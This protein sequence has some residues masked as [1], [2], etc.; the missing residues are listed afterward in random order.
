ML[1]PTDYDISPYGSQRSLRLRTVPAEDTSAVHFDWGS[2]P[3][4]AEEPDEPRNL[5]ELPLHMG[6]KRAVWYT[7]VLVFLSLFV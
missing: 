1:T 5:R 4:N 7:D 3:E 2:T 6:L